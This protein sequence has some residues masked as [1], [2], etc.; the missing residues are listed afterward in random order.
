MGV[1]AGVVGV[2]GAGVI[3]GA[4]TIAVDGVITG[5]RT[6]AVDGV[7]TG[8]APGV[9]TGARTAAVEGVWIIVALE[10]I[11][12]GAQDDIN[13]KSPQRKIAVN[14]LALLILN[15]PLIFCGK[16]FISY[17]LQGCQIRVRND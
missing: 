8:A 17:R 14:L 10:V 2:V 16:L 9:I 13:R 6:V 3:T 11:A 15:L 12:A 4:G 7:I 5:A 1:G